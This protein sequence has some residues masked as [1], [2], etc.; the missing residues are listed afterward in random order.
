MYLSYI[1]I[2]LPI[3]LKWNNK[4]KFHLEA[5]DSQSGRIIKRKTFGNTNGDDP[6]CG[7]VALPPP[8]SR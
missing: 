8:G 4:Y 2:I 3:C 1:K 6:E 7:G 5:K